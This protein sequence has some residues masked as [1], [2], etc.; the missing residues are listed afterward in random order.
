MPI[1]VAGPV[2]EKDGKIL[3]VQRSKKSKSY[4]EMWA[5]PGG[6]LNDG[7]DI[8]DCIKREAKEE[9]GLDIDV[10]VPIDVFSKTIEGEHYV[11]I[12]YLSNHKAGE[13]KLNNENQAFK[14]V[15]PKKAIEMEDLTSFTEHALYAYLDFI[16]A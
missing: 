13:V 9:A 1:V 2:I 7:E 4:P 6:K 14:W 12:V 11:S 15:D 3:L 16:S 5:L 8:I 10:F